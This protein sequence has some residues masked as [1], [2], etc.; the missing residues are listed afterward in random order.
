MPPIRYTVSCLEPRTHHIDVEVRVPV[1]AGASVTLAMPVWSPGSYSVDD[2]AG[3][4]HGFTASDSKGNPLAAE[5][6]DKSSFRVRAGKDRT[7][8]A[9]YKVFALD[10]D[11]HRSYLDEHRCTVN[12][13]CV[14]MYVEGSKSEPVEVAFRMPPGWKRIDTGL[15]RGRD[16][17]TYTAA[18]Y[19]ELVDCPVFMGNHHSEELVIQGVPH[20]IALTGIG[21]F[22]LA[23]LREDIRRI[24][25]QGVAVFGE[26]PYRHYTFLMEMA[27]EA[28]GGLEHRN[29]THMI[30][31]AFGFQ[32]RKDYIVALGLISHEFFHTWNV[33]RLRPYALGPFDYSKEVYTDLLWLAEGFTSYYDLLLTLRGGCMT[34]REYFDELGRELRRL[35]MHP[36]RAVQSLADSSRDTWVKLYRPTPD[37]PNTTISYYNKGCLFGMAL[38]LEIRALTKNRRNLDHVM[39]R[40]YREHYR[41]HDRGITLPDVLAACA[42]VAGQSL[43]PL[44][45]LIVDGTHEVDWNRYLGYAGLEIDSKQ[46]PRSPDRLRPGDEKA[47][48]WLG[49]RLRAESG[50]TYVTQTLSDGP[51]YAAGISPGDELIA[52]DALRC[53]EGRIDRW[54]SSWAPG[55]KVAVTIS[56]AGQLHTLTC[57]LAARPMF[58]FAIQPK[59]S[60]TPLEKAICRSWV[61]EAWSKL[62]RPERGFDYRPRER[63]L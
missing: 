32:P 4:V 24:V 51:A 8:V 56:R 11:V 59:R 13:T 12:G 23:V 60:A 5:K 57:E 2:F 25:E 18:D 6:L 52:L 44:F 38:D 54:L 48:C 30:F 26:M 47:R 63:I 14:F 34:P 40:L 39:R 58:D 1:S 46:K 21:N 45:D 61:T 9:S 17:R 49:V 31:P 28:Y 62:D 3:R 36:G 7:V 53:D 22:D 50:S 35:W 55:R 20:R 41:K 16:A 29:S 10:T 33:K 19:D 43:Q 37:S 42:E 15:E 27:P